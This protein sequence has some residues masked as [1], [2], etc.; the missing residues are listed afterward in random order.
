[1]SGGVGG[2][3]SDGRPYPYSWSSW[4]LHLLNVIHR[5]GSVEVLFSRTIETEVRKPVFILIGLNPIRLFSGGSLGAK[6]EING[7]ISVR[8]DPLDQA[9]DFCA[10]ILPVLDDRSMLKLINAERPELSCGRIGG[11]GEFVGLAAIEPISISVLVGCKVSRPL[12]R[13]SGLH[14]W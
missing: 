6:V 12:T 5:P 1:M 7:A 3:L 8:L 13:H 14:G 10:L 4:S 9:A 2:A 11:N